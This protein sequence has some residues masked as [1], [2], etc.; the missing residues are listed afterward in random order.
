MPLQSIKVAEFCNFFMYHGACILEWPFL[1]IVWDLFGF[2]FN[3]GSM[4]LIR[5]L[6]AH[7]FESLGWNLL[8]NVLFVSQ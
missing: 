3:E 6:G 7:H 8:R 2:A 4:S 1:G 5:Q